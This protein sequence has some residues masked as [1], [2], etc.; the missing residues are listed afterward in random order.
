MHQYS[1]I[2][3]VTIL[4]SRLAWHCAL[5]KK[6]VFYSQCIIL[7][8]LY[9]SNNIIITNYSHTKVIIYM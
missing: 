1:P 5:V 3:K 6:V 9:L 4:I 8:S 2:Q 7:D